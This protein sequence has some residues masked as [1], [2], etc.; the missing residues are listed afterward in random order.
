MPR[1]GFYN[2]N[3]YR[4]YP[5]TV[6]RIDSLPADLVVDCGFIMGIDSGFDPGSD[7]VYLHE[8]RKT[9]TRIEIEFRTTATGAASLPLVFSR[10]FTA[11][12][13]TT[14][15]KATTHASSACATE[16]VWEGFVVSGVIG[17]ITAQLTTGQSL[18]FYVGG[19]HT[20]QVEPARIQSLKGAYLR[21]ISVGNY[22]RVT[23][24]ECET[25]QSSSSAGAITVA[26]PTIVVNATCLKGDI[27]LKPGVNC[28]ITQNDTPKRLTIS[29]ELSVSGSNVEAP[30]LCALGG[31]L[32]LTPA[33]AAAFAANTLTFPVLKS[34]TSSSPAEYSKFLSGGPACN[35]V[36]SSINGLG[37]P[38]VKIGGG[39]GI[40][41]VADT[42]N[43]H[44][45]KL[46]VANNLLNAT[47]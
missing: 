16:P 6:N 20:R 30:T 3:E 38:D 39:A 11:E 18:S 34:G 41:V 37:A 25:G 19:I 2:D 32:P 29:A 12:E 1:A 10:L 26:S 21:S 24:S 43:P 28:S 15:F 23:I 46:R 14:E 13:W 9:A 35:Q 27:R 4:E 33:E 47:C 45:I 31:E 7:Y 44:T 42:V 5:F 40:Q 17:T 22:S 8:V 36:I